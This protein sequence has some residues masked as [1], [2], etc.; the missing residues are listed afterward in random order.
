MRLKSLIILLMLVA[1]SPA[2]AQNKGK[3]KPSGSP[4]KPKMLDKPALAPP[5]K[6]TTVEGITEYRLANGLRVLMFPDQSKQTI[7]VNI[8]YLV[9]SKHENYGETGMAH[10]LEHLVFKGTPKHPNIP[11]ELT[12]HGARPNGTTWLDRTNYF[13]TFAATEE[14]LKWALDLESDRMVNSYIAKKDLDSEMTVVRN[15]FESGENSPFR[16]LWQRVMA[17]AFEWHNYGKSTIGARADIENVPIERLQAFYRKHYQPDNA[18]LMI[19][20][21]IDEAKTL[22]MVNEKFGPLAKPER[23]LQTTYTKDP[24]Q[25]GERTVTVKRVGDVQLAMVGYHIPPGTH[26]DFAAIEVMNQILSTE[27]GGRLYKALVDT[28]KASSVGSFNFQLQDPGI[29]LAF[30]EVLKEKSLDDAKNTMLKVFDE[31]NQNLPSKEE[32][33]RAKTELLKNIDLSFNSSERIGLELS[34]YI[35]M[36]DWRMLFITRDKIKAVSLLDIKR[37]AGK[38]FKADNRTVGTFIPTEK[39]DRAEIPDAP[40]VQE[41]VKDYK[42]TQTIAEGE[43]FD[44]APANIESRTTKTTLPNGSKVAFLSK[45]T[46]GESVQARMTFRFGNEQ[47]LA[48]KGT[49]GELTASMLN[50]GTAKRT[51]QQIKDEFDKLKANVQIFGNAQQAS[52]NIETT[53]PNLIEVLKLAAEVVKEASFPADEFEKLKEEEIAG[54]ESQR[55]E[56]TAK[57][58]I[59]M[60]QHMNPY[61]KSDPRYVESFD[62]SVASI[63]ATKL[64]ELKKFHADFY[65]ANNATMSFVGDFDEPAVKALVTELFGNWKSA[66]PYQ[67]LV[68][69]YNPVPAINES[70]ETPDKANAFFVAGLGMEMRDDNPDYPA[71]VL[72]NYMLGGGFLN[73]RLATR[74]RQK[75]GLS[76]GVGSQFFAGSL[77]NVGTFNAFAIYAPENVAKLEAAFKD[78]I[79]KVIT[80]GFTA[81]EVAAA[82]SGWTQ[83]QSVTRAQDNSLASTLNNYQFINR[84]MKWVENYEKQVNALTVDQINAAMKKYLKPDMISI[85]KAGDFAKAASKK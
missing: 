42:G 80:T 35:G 81:E 65:G 10:L 74:I 75:E 31:F 3:Q 4:E 67:R 50:K 84:D 72:G 32:L 5:V 43:A 36:G 59:R 52:V 9:G 14:N 79:Q 58:S 85:I 73:S 49:I 56:P 39:P 83:G 26:P 62:E 15:E 19:A 47:T 71:L 70:I 63:K 17:T 13:E 76:Y 44:P 48:N 34:E 6:V 27:P 28:K 57:A 68:S 16:V 1:F 77:D 24:T 18:V 37:V 60:Q 2:F 38:Y 64:E 11:Q 69:K 21:K 53:R 82:K 29:F 30:A 66:T 41:L 33:E 25:D 22:E 54:I 7:T 45:K 8:T 46:R 78:E 12:E 61:P 23:L 55:S 20:G 40:N 51:R